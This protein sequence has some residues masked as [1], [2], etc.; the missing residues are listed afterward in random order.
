MMIRTTGYESYS[1]NSLQVVDGQDAAEK[2]RRLV[3]QARLANLWNRITGRPRTLLSYKRMH[4]GYRGITRL[5]RGIH[6]IPVKSIVGSIDRAEDFDQQF[7][8]L[9]TRLKNRWINVHMLSESRGWEPIIVHK[10]GDLYFVE[11]GHNRVSVARHTGWKTIEAQ[12]FE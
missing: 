1:G 5:D 8:P 4:A 7:R 3:Q 10:I 6:A 11:D 9:N 2:F 12:V